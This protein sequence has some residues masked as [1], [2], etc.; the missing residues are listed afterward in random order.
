VHIAPQ[1]SAEANG[2]VFSAHLEDVESALSLSVQGEASLAEFS[3]PPAAYRL[4]SPTDPYLYTVHLRLTH[5]DGTLVDAISVRFGVRHAQFKD[6]GFYLNGERLFL[7]GLNRHQTYPY[8]G[9]A[10]PAR[11]QRKDA[12]IVRYELG[13]NVVRT[14]HYPQSTHFL[15]RC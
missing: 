13:C 14:S 8:I 7:R 3:L 6:D 5:A 4:W 9:A 10:A 2:L 12:E 11:L 1:F 15:D